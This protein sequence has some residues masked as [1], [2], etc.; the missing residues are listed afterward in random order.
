MYKEV[1]RPLLARMDSET[2]HMRAREAFHLTESSPLALQ[3]LERL[4]TYKHERFTSERLNVVVGGV[5][6]DNPVVVGAGW[7]KQGRAVRA[8]YRLGFAGVEVGTVVAWDQDG[9]PKPRQFIIGPGVA[10]NRL[11]FNSPGMNTVDKNLEAYLESGIPIGVSLGKNKEVLEEDAPFAHAIVAKRLYR[12]ATWFTIN[13]SSPNTPGL[14][15]LQDKGPLTDIAQEVNQVMDELGGRK[16]LFVKIAPDLPLEDVDAVIDVVIN[17]GLAGI[18]ASNTTSPAPDLKAKYGER[19]RNEQGGLSGDD[20]DFRQMS[21]RQIE[22]IWRQTNGTVDVIGVGGVKDA[23][24]ALEKILLG[25]K[26]VQVVTGIVGEGPTLPGRINRGLAEFMDKHG[27][28][29]ISKLVGLRTKSVTS[30]EE[31]LSG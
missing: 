24:T 25:A 9:N 1:V 15:A 31:L 30:I 29:D 2:W 18:V 11:G 3:L 6:L 19:W 27:F 26:S 22:H 17:E 8:L 12:H 10:I 28:T 16:P 23:P 21:N 5:V 7:D 14:R 4:V 20:N 13:V